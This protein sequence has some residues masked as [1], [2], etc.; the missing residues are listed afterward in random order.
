MYD[1]DKMF[2]LSV[3]DPVLDDARDSGM[4]AE[5]YIVSQTLVR[6]LESRY[7]DKATAH[8]IRSFAGG[9]TTEEALQSLT[10]QP[11]TALDVD[12][13]NWGRSERRLFENPPGPT[14]E[15]TAEDQIQRAEP[16]TRGKLGGGTLRPLPIKKP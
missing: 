13:R 7:G 12:F 11:L 1:N 3:L 14:Y 9:A 15:L 10:G 16:E 4:M 8:L 2:A 5:A 6:Y